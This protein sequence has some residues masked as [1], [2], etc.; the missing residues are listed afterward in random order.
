MGLTANQRIDLA[1][2]MHEFAGSRDEPMCLDMCEAFFEYWEG[3][4]RARVAES[5][6]RPT[7]IVLAWPHSTTTR[8]EARYKRNTRG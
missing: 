2:S 4:A 7:A 3:R 5:E 1:R 8:A 6:P